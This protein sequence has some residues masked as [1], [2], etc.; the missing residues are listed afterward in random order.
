MH[1]AGRLYATCKK[2][3]VD[4]L[5]APGD[6][7]V[8]PKPTAEQIL[9]VSTMFSAFENADIPVLGITGNHDIGGAGTTPMDK[10]VAEIGHH[11]R[12]C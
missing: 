11:A 3:K 2:Q 6:F 4:V 8:N 1:I 7:F 5:V 9:L 10:V 12:W